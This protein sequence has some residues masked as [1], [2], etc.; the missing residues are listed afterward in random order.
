MVNAKTYAA[1][2]SGDYYFGMGGFGY[3]ELAMPNQMIKILKG[4]E[5]SGLPKQDLEFW[6]AHITLDLEH[7]KTWFS[8]MLKLIK[9]SEQ[10]QRCL[11]GGSSLLEARA[12]MFD[13][14]LRFL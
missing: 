4:L 8:E 12:K 13:S 10:A 6:D 14:I 11:E 1:F 9:N 7:G 2:L 5:K 3:I